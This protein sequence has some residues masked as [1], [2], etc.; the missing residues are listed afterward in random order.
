MLWNWVVETKAYPHVRSRRRRTMATFC[1]RFRG[2]DDSSFSDHEFFDE[3]DDTKA[4]TMRDDDY[5]LPEKPLRTTRRDSGIEIIGSDS[6]DSHIFLESTDDP[7]RRAL[8]KEPR[9]SE[10]DS[11]EDVD[12]LAKYDFSDLSVPAVN[13]KL[14]TFML[15]V[16]KFYFWKN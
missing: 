9:Y 14:V 5:L 4:D 2:V 1:R 16:S 6:D 7:R 15:F 11:E 13:S 8:L 12:L 10:S 3:K